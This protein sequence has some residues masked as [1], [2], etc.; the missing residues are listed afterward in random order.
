[1][2]TKGKLKT[3]YHEARTPVYQEAVVP[4]EENDPG[5]I[6]IDARAIASI[7]KQAV[8][9]VEGVTRLSGNSI[10]DNIAEFVG[11]RKIQ[12]RSLQVAFEENA[13]SVEVAVNVA[14]GFSL[15]EVAA[16]VQ[17]SV[18]SAIE[19]LTGLSV[20]QVNVAIREIEEPANEPESGEMNINE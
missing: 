9:E 10:V 13:V 1:M 16:E 2:Q 17:Q 8:C 6:R 20:R 15:P 7:A 11:S 18:S 12:D 14:Y 3:K 19:Q 4:A 5:I